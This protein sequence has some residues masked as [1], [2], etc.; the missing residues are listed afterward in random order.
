MRGSGYSMYIKL[1]LIVLTAMMLFYS[2]VVYEES[3]KKIATQRSVNV[4]VE[5]VRDTWAALQP[6]IGIWNS[7]YVQSNEITDLLKLEANLRL[8]KSGLRSIGNSLIE[9]NRKA[10]SF[11]Q[12]DIGLVYRCLKNSP[13][14]FIV[15]ANNL[16]ALVAGLSH[17]DTRPDLKWDQLSI[18]NNDGN[19]RA[20]YNELC[21]L[22]RVGED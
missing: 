13:Q 5:Q 20:I 8:D 19:I 18:L 17:V 11:D 2:K 6:T 22:M 3:N 15:G 21:L 9:S 7:R 16:Q 10:E 1:S 14:G 4:R 12:T